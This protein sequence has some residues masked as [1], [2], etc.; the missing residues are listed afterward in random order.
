MTGA[1]TARTAL[2]SAFAL[3][4][5]LLALTEQFAHLPSLVVAFAAA[6]PLVSRADDEVSEPAPR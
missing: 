4:A 1:V 6:A 3:T 2:W 5:T